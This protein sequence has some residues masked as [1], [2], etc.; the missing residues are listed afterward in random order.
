MSLIFQMMLGVIR[1]KDVSKG[2]F[3]KIKSDF[4]NNGPLGLLLTIGLCYMSDL[5]HDALG[6]KGEHLVNT[7]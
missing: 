6:I 1:H 3:S 2:H 7:I 5:L 4:L